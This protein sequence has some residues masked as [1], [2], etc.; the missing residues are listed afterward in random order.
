MDFLIADSG[1][2]QVVCMK[3]IISCAVMRLKPLNCTDNADACHL[4]AYYVYKNISSVLMIYWST[5]A[6]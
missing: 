5:E 4:L 6:C 2:E 3:Q 1:E